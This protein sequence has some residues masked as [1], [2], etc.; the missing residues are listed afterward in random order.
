MPDQAINA[1]LDLEGLEVLGASISSESI[2]LVIQ[3]RL[4]AG[5]CQRCGGIAAEPKERPQVLVRDLSVSGHAVM[6]RWIKRRWRCGYCSQTWTE[7]HPQIPPRARMTVRFKA[8]LAQQAIREKNFSQV[9]AT[10]GVSYDTV[11]RAHRAR[12]ELF[13]RERSNPPPR[14]LAIDEAAVRRATAIAP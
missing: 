14:V 12:A 5:S 9:A 13:E 7:S 1:T 8:H 6:V 3:S 4:E 2:E 10:S 11:A